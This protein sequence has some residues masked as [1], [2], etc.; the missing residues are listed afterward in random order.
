MFRV[1]KFA[2][3]YTLG[4]SFSTKK[5]PGILFGFSFGLQ[6]A[7]KVYFWV[8]NSKFTSYQKLTA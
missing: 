1:S 8:L 7:F 4:V 6:R 5:A 3:W 2:P